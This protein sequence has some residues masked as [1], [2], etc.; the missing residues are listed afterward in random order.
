MSPNQNSKA[1][2]M[3][4]VYE[5]SP[6]RLSVEE[7]RF[8]IKLTVAGKPLPGD[9]HSSALAELGI[10]RRIDVPEEKD[11]GLK[12]A[13]CWKVARKALAAK[14][15]EKLHQAMHDLERLNNDRDRNETRRL[16]ELSDL[17]RQIA[18]GITVRL[19]GG[20]K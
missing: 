11:T 20:R 18:R 12:I 5:T 2:S 4:G 10:L 16:F 9:Y 17:G 1:K 15:S 13:E 19:S 8:I 14:D 7:T 3:V 6:I